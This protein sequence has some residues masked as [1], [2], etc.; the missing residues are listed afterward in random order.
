MAEILK[1]AQ[2][3]KWKYW[4]GATNQNVSDKKSYPKRGGLSPLVPSPRTARELPVFVF[5]VLVTENWNDDEY[6]KIL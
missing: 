5:T 4:Q 3:K 6:G 2:T 1:G